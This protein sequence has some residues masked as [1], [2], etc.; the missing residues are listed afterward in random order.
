MTK[1]SFIRSALVS[2][3]VLGLSAVACGGGGNT[4]G[5]YAEVVA[6]LESPSGTVDA[7]SAKE[8]GPAFEEASSQGLGSVRESVER[9]ASAQS[10]SYEQACSGGGSIK[11]TAEGN[12]QSA[13]VSFSY[14][15]CCESEC[16]INGSGVMYVSADAAAEYSQCGGYDMTV[17]CGTD[18]GTINFQGCIGGDST[19]GYTYL[20]TVDDK[21]YAVSGTYSNG[22][23]TLT[24]KGENGTFECTY[25]DGAGSC[26]GDGEFTF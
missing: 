21:T 4:P 10:G 12:Q 5:S 19:Y 25:T 26:T 20:I 1:S 15:N 14:A 8:I 11:A 13:K 22:N 24:I 2:S 6:A 7:T 9:R 16:C 18:I 3:M 17:T 23:G